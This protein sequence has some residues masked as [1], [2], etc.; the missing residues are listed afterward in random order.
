[1]DLRTQTATATGDL[2]RTPRRPMSIIDSERWLG[3]LLIGPAVLY[4]VLLVGVAVFMAL[5][6]SGLNTTTAGP[7]P[8][9]VR[10]P[11]FTGRVGTPGFHPALQKPLILALLSQAWV[12]S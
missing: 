7:T 3:P 1:M 9:F 6:F 11:N 5:C 12:S 8:G 4:V 2:T 10:L